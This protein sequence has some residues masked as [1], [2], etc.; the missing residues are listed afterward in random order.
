MQIRDIMTHPVRT[1]KAMAS[2]QFAAE[3]M[4]LHDVGALPVTLDEKLVG[5][6][7]DRDVVIR[8]LAAGLDPQN[9]EVERIMTTHPVALS[10][11]APIE[12]AAHTFTNLR[13][14][15]LP[16]VEH[17]YPVGMLTVDDIA[18]QW[19]DAASILI[20][21]RRIAPRNRRPSVA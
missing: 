21:A 4:A 8:C 12:E 6:L 2:V 5:I 9:T 13:I 7:T 15:R 19:D 17:D 11:D 10:P 20:M 16:I 1:V 18:R 3:M 14:R